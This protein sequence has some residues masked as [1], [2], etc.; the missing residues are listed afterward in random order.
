MLIRDWMAEEIITVD[1]NTSV[2]VA[3]RMM[4]ENNV[5]RLP[6]VSH[7]QLIGIVTDRDLKEA[8]PS[9]TNSMDIHELY[10]LLSEMRL[11]EIMSNNPVS[12]DAD[13][14]LEMAAMVMLENKIS[15]LPITDASGQ[16]VG[17]IS[18]SDILRGF[19]YATGLTANANMFIL[20]VPDQVGATSKIIDIFRKH[21]ARLM[22]VLTAYADA[23]EGMKRVSV[24][25]TCP[26]ENEK[27]IYDEVSTAST[28][29]FHSKDNFDSIPKTQN[30]DLLP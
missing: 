20:D 23:P 7:G 27:I 11:K 24:R 18:E 15:G 22:S 10:Y 12:L 28:I 3:T 1:E 2:M 30:Q 14:T 9:K 19:I 26:K 4:K 16:L 13:E 6:V 25:I 29:V 8:S 17:L 21:D 5:R